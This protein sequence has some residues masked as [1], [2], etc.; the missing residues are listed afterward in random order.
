M[1]R[2]KNIIIYRANLYDDGV[3]TQYKQAIYDGKV[4]ISLFEIHKDIQII[5]QETKIFMMLQN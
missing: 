4:P 2:D 5:I 3:S 1:S